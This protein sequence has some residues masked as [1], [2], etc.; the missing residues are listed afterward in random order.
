MYVK[1]LS[2]DQYFCVSILLLLQN[3][4]FYL[5]NYMTLHETL[6]ESLL[7]AVSVNNLALKTKDSTIHNYIQKLGQGINVAR[8]VNKCY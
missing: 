3:H 4:L 5:V 6:R 7:M 2:T 8:N 1:I